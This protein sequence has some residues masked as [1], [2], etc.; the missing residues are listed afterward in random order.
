MATFTTQRKCLLNL[1]AITSS[2]EGVSF[3]IIAVMYICTGHLF[4]LG[5]TINLHRASNY[6]GRKYI[7]KTIFLL[8]ANRCEYLDMLQSSTR[9]SL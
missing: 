5:Q 2:F 3:P 1:I 4:R 9:M 6:C 8:V 7:S